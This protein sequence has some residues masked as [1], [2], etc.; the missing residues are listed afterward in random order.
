MT[1]FNRSWAVVFGVLEICPETVPVGGCDDEAN[2]SGMCGGDVE[3]IPM[4]GLVGLR[5]L[6]GLKPPPQ[7]CGVDLLD[8]TGEIIGGDV[9]L[10][11]EEISCQ[12]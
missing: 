4:L 9:D 11:N 6:R 10:H 8:R 1:L 2:T 5:G 7:R 3:P 12:K